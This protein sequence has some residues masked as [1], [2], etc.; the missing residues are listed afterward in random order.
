M[1]EFVCTRNI[2]SLKVYI[3]LCTYYWLLL[4]NSCVIMAACLDGVFWTPF[5]ISLWLLP[6]TNAFQC[7][8]YQNRAATLPMTEHASLMLHFKFTKQLREKVREGESCA[9]A[10]H[11]KQRANLPSRLATCISDNLRSIPAVKS[12][13][14]PNTGLLLCI[15]KRL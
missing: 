7:Q 6:C 5:F 2:I 4:Y 9:P 10:V 3:L 14:L 15:W 8:L 13:L 11:G 1:H 12:K